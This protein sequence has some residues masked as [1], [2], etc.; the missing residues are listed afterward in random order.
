[1]NTLERITL[2]LRLSIRA[3]RAKMNP[4]ST[5]ILGLTGIAHTAI[6]PEGTVF[7]R[8]ELWRARSQMNVSR[9]ENVRVTGV[10]GLMLDVEAE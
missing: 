5:G 4:G 10:E 8:G 2:M 1:M 9:G 6:A 3:R 7:V